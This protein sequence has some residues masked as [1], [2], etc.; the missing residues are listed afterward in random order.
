VVNDQCTSIIKDSPL[1]VMTKLLKHWPIWQGKC[2]MCQ[3]NITQNVFFCDKCAPKMRNRAEYC[4]LCPQPITNNRHPTICGKCL[5]APPAWTHLVI[6]DDYSEAIQK[7]LWRFKYQ[8]QHDA[9]RWLSNRLRHQLAQQNCAPD[10]TLVPVPLHTSKLR[11]RGFNQSLEIAKHLSR[12]LNLRI[13]NC[14]IRTKSTLPQHALTPTERQRNLK[15][16]FT[17]NNTV[18][19]HIA[20]V[21]DVMTTGSTLNQMALVCKQGGARIIEVWCCA[22]A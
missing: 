12:W 1:Q 21:D 7:T 8:R 19:E 16:A 20:L 13:D 9:G 11:R 6:A 3:K 14:C 15:G 18:P 5:I 22:A 4:T 10:I 2:Q 17:C